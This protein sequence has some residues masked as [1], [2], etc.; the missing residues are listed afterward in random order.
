MDK[1]DAKPELTDEVDAELKA[2][3]TEFFEG[4]E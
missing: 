2:A 3:L 1:I 4:V